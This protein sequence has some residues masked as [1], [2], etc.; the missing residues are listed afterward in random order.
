[1]NDLTILHLSDLH[2]TWDVAVQGYPHPHKNLIAD[3]EKQNKYLSEPIIIVVTGDIINQGN[4]SDYTLRAVLKFFKDLKDVLQSKVKNVIIVP[5]NHEKEKIDIQN[6]FSKLYLSQSVPMEESFEELLD[7]NNRYYKKYLTLAN[8]I[9]NIFKTGDTIDQTYGVKKVCLKNPRDDSDLIFCFICLNS[10]L[11]CSK[12]KDY[13]HLRLGSHQIKQICDE[14]S[15]K[16]VSGKDEPALTFVVS[17]HPLSWLI[18]E[19]EDIVQ[20]KILSPAEWNANILLCGHIHQR[21]A[22]GMRN[23]HHSLTTLTT[24]FGWPDAGKS[25][26]ENHFYS[27]YVFNLDYNSI[28]IYARATSDGGEFIPDFR[29]YGG[30]SDLKY[31]SKIV[32]PIDTNKTQAYYEIG[33]SS[34]RSTKAFYFSDSFVEQI[35]SYGAQMCLF[36]SHISIYLTRLEDNFLSNLLIQKVEKQAGIDTDVGSPSN[37]SAESPSSAS[38]ESPSS[39]SAE[40]PSS[41]SAES[42][43]NANDSNDNIEKATNEVTEKKE[44]LSTEHTLWKDHIENPA[45]QISPG[46]L[47]FLVNNEEYFFKTFSTFM[48]ALCMHV[49]NDL[50]NLKSSK[51]SI[52][53]NELRFHARYYFCDESHKECYKQFC[54]AQNSGNTDKTLYKPKDIPW[55]NSLIQAAFVSQKSLI[56]QNNTRYAVAPEKR[57]SNFITIVPSFE[58]NFKKTEMGVRPLL[59]FG[60]SCAKKEYDILLYL[61]EFFK[62]ENLLGNIMDSF[63]RSFPINLERYFENL[64]KKNDN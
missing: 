61:L 56:Y 52:S 12:E 14:Y 25:H 26:S 29:F 63:L 38:A 55:E 39:A 49:I 19:E 9:Y 59:T 32:Y 42:P 20:D 62:I 30:N 37:T 27:Y 28:D 47:K 60:L 31:K 11:A 44:E 23:N 2:I 13:R 53:S 41:A 35:E 50:C 64:H 6:T 48:Q 54:V 51:L 3:I 45:E 33:S 15:E 34:G 5:G 40:S 17:H 7:L 1:M 4:Y 22:I 16:I 8:K 36:Q 24:G 18:G 43:S 46:F 57:W 10:T 58:K 21:D